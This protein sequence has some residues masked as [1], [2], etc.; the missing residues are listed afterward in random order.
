MPGVGPASTSFPVV[1]CT[2]MD[3]VAEPRHD[4]GHR[5]Y[6]IPFAAWYQPTGTTGAVTAAADAAGQPPLPCPSF[7]VDSVAPSRNISTIHEISELFGGSP[8][9]RSGTR[10]S[11]PRDPA[12]ALPHAGG[13]RPGR[14]FGRRHRRPP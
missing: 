14:N 12:R 1:C 2:D 11:R 3:A 8:P 5:Q 10:R 13:A 4:D 6:V 9:D 7:T